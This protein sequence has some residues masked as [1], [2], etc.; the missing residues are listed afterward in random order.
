MPTVKPEIGHKFRFEDGSIGTIKEKYSRI[1]YRHYP[2]I[3]VYSKQYGVSCFAIKAIE[4]IP[5]NIAQC[6]MWQVKP[7]EK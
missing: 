7:D 3:V 2:C 1:G 4:L 5:A 6:Q